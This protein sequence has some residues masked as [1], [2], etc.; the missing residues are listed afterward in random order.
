MKA[1]NS[2]QTILQLFRK[3][4]HIEYGERCT[5]GSHAVQAGLIAKEK[6][7]DDELVLAAFL[8]DIGHLYPLEFEQAEFQTM[9]NFGMDAHDR[10][11]EEFLK[12][13]GFSERIIATVKNHVAAKRYLCLADARYYDQL[14][15]ASK[16]TL[17]YQGGPMSE[18][19]ARAFENDPFFDDSILIRLV[20]DEAKAVD[21]EV[22]EE[23]WEYFTTLLE[24]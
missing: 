8:H 20:D 24:G 5:Q 3:H 11:G 4:G 6:G 15:E 22:T 19:E 17:C 21:F 1:N 13:N 14:S 10:W 12:I 23:H 9:G 16:E 7:F 2:P 18:E